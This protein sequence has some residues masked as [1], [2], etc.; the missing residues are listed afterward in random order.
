[1]TYCLLLCDHLSKNNYSGILV[2]LKSYKT[3]HIKLTKRD[4]IE[5]MTMRNNL[6]KNFKKI[7]SAFDSFNNLPAMYSNKSECDFCFVKDICYLHNMAY[8]NTSDHPVEYI[9]SSTSK[10]FNY[11]RE[12]SHQ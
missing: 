3:Y 7:Y 1:M 6:A 9:T 8:E 10:T 11:T 2:Y 5:V 12:N 4:I